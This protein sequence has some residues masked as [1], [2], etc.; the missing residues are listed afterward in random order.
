[1][2]VSFRGPGLHW[3]EVRTLLAPGVDADGTPLL[4]LGSEE[5]SLTLRSF[6]HY[7]TFF[8]LHYPFLVSPR[9]LRSVFFGQAPRHSGW[10]QPQGKTARSSDNGEE[11]IST[12]S[13]RF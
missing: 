1:M 3:K 7:F 6:G 8:H 13:D 5:A 4:K 11:P 10:Y 12:L 2:E 9:V